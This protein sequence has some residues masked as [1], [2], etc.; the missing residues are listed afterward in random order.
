MKKSV[1]NLLLGASIA[2]LAISASAQ[3]YKWKDA[4][5][6]TQYSD[7]PPPAGTNKAQ[8]VETRDMPVSSISAPKVAPTQSQAKASAA[9]SQ[10]AQQARSEKDP[11][12]CGEL[13]G[14]LRFLQS[15]QLAKT[16]NNRGEVEFMTEEKRNADIASVQKEMQRFCP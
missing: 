15:G 4:N 6:V 13:Q 16:V 2:V 3:I 10:P 11:K 7:T 9:A 12:I 1:V 5:G 14:R 8:V